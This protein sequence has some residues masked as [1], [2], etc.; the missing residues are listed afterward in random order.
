MRRIDERQ[1]R[2][3]LQDG[4]GVTDDVHKT[5]NERVST[6]PPWPDS[7]HVVPT[8]GRRGVRPGSLPGACCA[9][10]RGAV[11]TPRGHRRARFRPGLAAV[12]RC[13]PTLDHE[14]GV[15]DHRGAWCDVSR[16]RVWRADRGNVRRG[17]LALVGLQPPDRDL[18]RSGSSVAGAWADTAG[19]RVRATAGRW[20]PRGGCPRKGRLVGRPPALSRVCTGR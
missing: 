3:T 10:A 14:Q 1:G 13:R 4:S 9:S 18:S 20:G 8:S 19:R 2:L 12:V 11:G 16:R 6:Q 7:L 15:D 5:P 17:P